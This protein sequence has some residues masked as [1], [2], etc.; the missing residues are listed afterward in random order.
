[1][2]D[3][4]AIAAELREMAETLNASDRELAAML[5]DLAVVLDNL[6]AFDEPMLREMLQ[7]EGIR[8]RLKPLNRE[9]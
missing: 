9:E 7:E 2:A 4:R 3:A 5:D 1:M 6:T 8:A